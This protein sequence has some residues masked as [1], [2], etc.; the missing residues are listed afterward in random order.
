MSILNETV[1]DAAA[2]TS[3]TKIDENRL[4]ML[5]LV[6]TPSLGPKRIVDALARLRAP[7]QIFALTLTELE[8]LGFPAGAA[9][10]IFDGKAR[11]AADEEWGKIVQQG[12]SIVTLGCAEYPERLKEIYD[13]PPVLWV[14]GNVQLLARPS[15]A[16]VGTRHPSPYGAGVAEMLSRD[17]S[18]RRLTIVSG[19]ARGID[20]C[21]HKGALAARTAT[22]A[23]WGTGIDVVYPKENRKLADEIV[24]TGG[25]IV[26]EMPMGTFPAPQNFPRRNRIISGLSIGVLVVEASENSG[27]RVTARCAAEQDRD[28]YAVPGNVTAKNSWT[29]NTLI[30]QGA[31]LVASWEDIWEDLPSQVRLQLEQ[32]A[33][34]ESKPENAASLLPD[35]ALRPEEAIVLQALRSDESLQIDDLLERLEAQLTSS[36]VFTALFELE[37][38]GR[39]RCLPGKNYVRTL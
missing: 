20:T 11:R 15:I 31:K 19:M 14:R 12:G 23:V 1:R 27:T 17:L 35:P 36:E 7:D 9:Q 38:S 34:L 29:P 37:M 21:A 8:G 10:F 6:L 32:E 5:A 26:S 39:I 4:A 16:V 33:G 22:I 24:A 30:K 2:E 28:L 3:E 25:T 18:A 13:P